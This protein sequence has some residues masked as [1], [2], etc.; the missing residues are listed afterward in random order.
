METAL[1][2]ELNSCNKLPLTEYVLF[3]R[4]QH[5]VNECRPAACLSIS[6][7][8]QIAK[9]QNN[10][11]ITHDSYIVVRR[12]L[13]LS[14]EFRNP[15]IPENVDG[16]T[17]DVESLR[18]LFL[19]EVPGLELNFAG[20]LAVSIGPFDRHRQAVEEEVL[21]PG[22]GDQTTLIGHL[23][24]VDRHENVLAGP[25]DSNRIVGELLARGREAGRNA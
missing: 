6:L 13:S 7:F 22:D 15:E 19:P 12:R 25:G 20:I 1:V 8:P 24:P 3:S 4:H 23:R 5:G 11:V 17:V 14:V 18:P 16:L 10:L 21:A 2:M 9:K